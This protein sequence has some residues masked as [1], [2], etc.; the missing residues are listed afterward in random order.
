MNRNTLIKL[1]HVGARKLFNNEDARREWQFAHTGH[2]SCKAMSN[3]DMERLVTELRRKQALEPRRPPKRAGRVPFNRSNYMNKIE[4]QLASMGLS[5]QYAERIAY[6]V[7]GGNGNK[8]NTSPGIKR[9]EWVRK[10]EHFRAIIAALDVE[11]KKRGLLASVEELLK[12]LGKEMT[13]VETIVPEHMSG[14]WNRNRAWLRHIV[15]ALKS[16]YNAS[17]GDVPSRQFKE[18]KGDAKGLTFPPEI[19]P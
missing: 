17:Q 4:A 2:T 18:H 3:A 11:Q 9:L 6:Q 1:V 10:A 8:P 16:E 19:E 14:K 5:W 7:T 12:Q 13:Y 15:E